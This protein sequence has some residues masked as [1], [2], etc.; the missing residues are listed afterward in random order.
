[1]MDMVVFPGTN[2]D[3][4]DSTVNVSLS[5]FPEPSSDLDTMVCPGESVTIGT[6]MLDA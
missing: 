2:A 6:E 3:G 5:F 1:M 4:C